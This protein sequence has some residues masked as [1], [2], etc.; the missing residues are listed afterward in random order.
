[1]EDLT[2][3]IKEELMKDEPNYKSVLILILESLSIQNE[4]LNSLE[5]IVRAFD[6]ILDKVEI[7][8]TDGGPSIG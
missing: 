1:M 5:N 7:R 3:V 2:K 4:R 6:E 8:K